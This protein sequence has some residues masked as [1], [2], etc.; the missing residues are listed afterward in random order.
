MSVALLAILGLA[1]AHPA[2]PSHLQLEVGRQGAHVELAVPRD[3]LEMALTGRPDVDLS[4]PAPDDAAVAA[5]VA[6]HL[7]L[8][9]ADGPLHL[10]VGAPAWRDV[11]GEPHAVVAVDAAPVSGPLVGDL[12]LT[13]AAIVETVR[14]HKVVVTLVRDVAEGASA[15]PRLLATLGAEHET[16]CVDRDAQGVLGTLWAGVG[17]GAR[18]VLDG[19]DHLLFLATL[20]LVAPLRRDEGG[21]AARTEGT[22]R[23]VLG[24]V[25][26]FTLGHSATLVAA[27]L[28]FLEVPSAPVEIAIAA[29]VVLGA[30]HA[31]RP[32]YAGREA[33][34]AASLGLVHGLGFASVLGRTGLPRSELAVPLVGFNLGIEMVQVGLVV[35]SLPVWW[36]VA[37][38]KGLRIGVAA[39]VAVVASG[40][41]VSR[42]LA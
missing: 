30:V 35:A 4:A 21:W 2:S 6:E 20:L 42:S 34:V 15:A 8:A 9:D 25:T 7:A 39:V 26:G 33:A 11:G 22:P 27:T 28:G 38:R 29:S 14:S 10:A 5:Y 3:Q 31:A 18:H 37:R 17:D 19:A 1:W 13:D 40:W 36:L 12:C 24:I 32:L 23:R 41:V 16:V